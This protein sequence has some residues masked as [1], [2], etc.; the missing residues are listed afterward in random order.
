MQRRAR[1]II[2]V[3]EE[4]RRLIMS[5]KQAVLVETLRKIQEGTIYDGKVNSVTDFGAFVDL[6][7]P[8]GRNDFQSPVFITTAYYIDGTW[9]LAYRGFSPS[10]LEVVGAGGT[11]YEYL[12]TSIKQRDEWMCRLACRL[13]L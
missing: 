6:L 2:E 12:L 5:E 11:S 1:Q 8:D 9:S 3:S 4:E 10:N 7:S 13:G